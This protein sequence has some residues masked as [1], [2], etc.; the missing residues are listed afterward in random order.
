MLTLLVLPKAHEQGYGG[1]N[2]G[3]VVLSTPVPRVAGRDIPNGGGGGGGS[4]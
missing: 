4:F 2:D 1:E 3:K